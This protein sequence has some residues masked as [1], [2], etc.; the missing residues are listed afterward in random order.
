MTQTNTTFSLRE[1]CRLALALCASVLLTVGLSA[2]TFPGS[3]TNTAGNSL[4]PSAGTG[5]CFA[6]PQTTIGTRFN[7]AVTGLAPGAV[8]SSVT[9]NVTHTWANDLDIYLISPTN[10]VLALSTDNGGLTGLDPGVTG[11]LVFNISSTVNVTTW[12]GGTPMGPYMAEGGASSACGG[13]PPTT[14]QTLGAFTGSNG[15]W[16]LVFYDDSGGDTGTMQNWSLNF[17]APPTCMVTCPPAINVST[18]AG[19]CGAVLSLPNPTFTGD[20]FGTAVFD[21]ISSGV[22]PLAGGTQLIATG[23]PITFP[24]TPAT[25]PVQICFDY[26]GDFGAAFE[27]TQ[28]LNQ[29]GAVVLS[30]AVG[31]DCQAQQVC[32]TIT[33]AAYNAQYA[34]TTQTFTLQPNTTVNPGLCLMNQAELRFFFPAGSVQFTNSLTG[35][36]PVTNFTFDVGTT[37]VTFTTFNSLGTPVTC[38]TTVTVVD[39]VAPVFGNCPT[40]DLVFNLGDGE[41]EITV[42]FDLM[43]TDNCPGAVIGETTYEPIPNATGAGS[44]FDI[45]FFDLTNTSVDPIIVTQLEP[46]YNNAIGTPTVFEIYTINGTTMG[47]ELNAAAFTLNTTAPTVSPG[48]G[49]SAPIVLTTPIA[50][51]PGATVGIGIGLGNPAVAGFALQYTFPPV[52][53][54]TPNPDLLFTAG[55]ATTTVFGGALLTPRGA[56]VIITYGQPGGVSVVQ[57][58]GVPFGTAFPTGTTLQTFVATDAFGNSSTCSFN[59]IINPLAVN[60]N[61]LVVNPSIQ[62]SLDP[63]ATCSFVTADAILEGGPY[64]CFD[65]FR[66]TRSPAVAPGFGCPPGPVYLGQVPITC[67]DIGR[68]VRVVITDPVTGNSQWSNII[69]EDKTAPIILGCDDITLPCNF[70]NT[71]TA[72]TQTFMVAPGVAIM[73]NSTVE[74][75]LPVNLPADASILDVNASIDITHTW[76]GDLTISIVS[77]TG[78]EV[79]LW[80]GFCGPTDNFRVNFDDE[81]TNCTAA[82]AAYTI[83]Q[84]LRTTACNVG[85]DPSLSFLSDFDFGSPAG[86]WRLRVTDDTGG[87]V[88]RIDSFALTIQF[89]SATG[90]GAGVTATDNCPG[91]TLRS[92]TSTTNG[93]CAVDRQ[94]VRTFIATDASGNTSVC[95]QR[96]TFARPT[97]AS[98]EFPENLD[99]IT[100]EMLDCTSAF[101]A[102]GARV[103]FGNQTAIVTPGTPIADGGTISVPITLSGFPADAQF[104]DLNVGVGLTYTAPQQL[105]VR[106]SR[107]FDPNFVTLI[108]TPCDPNGVAG[109]DDIRATFDDSGAAIL[110][111][112]SFAPVVQG[113]YRP[114]SP[115]SVFNG[116]SVNGTY[117]LTLRDFFADPFN[118]DFGTLDSLRF[119]FDYSTATAITV[120]TIGGLPINQLTCGINLTTDERVIDV[121]PTSYKV[122]RVF[123]ALDMCTGVERVSTQIITVM[124]Q[125]GPILQAPRSNLLNQIDLIA[126]STQ[127]NTNQISGY[128]PC[129]GT[130]TVP[131]INILGDDCSGVS[132]IS[133]EIY[134]VDSTLLGA[135]A[136]NG[137]VFNNL[138][139]QDGIFVSALREPDITYR[140][141]YLVDDNCGNQTSTDVFYNVIERT[142]PVADCDQITSVNITGTDTTFVNASVFD[143][144]SYDVCGDVYFYA[145]RMQPVRDLVPYGNYFESD[146]FKTF[147]PFKFRENVAFTCADQTVMVYFLVVD[148][149]VQGYIDFTVEV[150]IPN[151]P[152]AVR[153]NPNTPYT[154]RADGTFF[155]STANAIG[156]RTKDIWE[157][158]YNPLYGGGARGRQSCSNAVDPSC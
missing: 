76:I 16:Q 63:T 92:T 73:D 7:A 145:R 138:P 88:G 79:V 132:T 83:G 68:P 32:V 104:T 15:T 155:L 111:C 81:A 114:G 33:A 23:F 52:P 74:A 34:G 57:T 84:T 157:G 27:I 95:T 64:R 103:T 124:D 67:A 107:Q 106:L 18:D 21:T 25:T 135:S 3:T 66:I 12:T 98:I 82:C 56:N 123:T 85:L 121:C 108:E 28:L 128:G 44:T 29:A 133:T 119:T 156:G 143:D 87:D 47:N 30:T 4:I 154:I 158:H 6:A 140:I 105:I 45:V 70:P 91:V 99:G 40:T 148:E 17:A 147:V 55:G 112:A 97:L 77:P 93:T 26:I 53:A 149:F 120:P 2:Q 94:V 69:V 144:G 122:R 51:A 78:T 109:I 150:T 39:N 62:A 101:P 90:A 42:D 50:I 86:N 43:V 117:I 129:L 37:T 75:I 10:Q 24:A 8:L 35:I 22:Q 115:L 139:L 9:I 49:N 1:W 13:V 125:T 137:G 60:N 152:A 100:G 151:L 14:I 61:G 71:A 11:P 5:G 136:T 38:T 118:P 146:N 72:G 127:V 96:I 110:D 126:I 130:V 19:I 116:Q 54:P 141:R 153:N 142:A 113:T 41:C 131:P 36:N 58:T 65:S 59:V 20:C 134:S 80:N 48:P 102:V 46:F 31:T 89:A